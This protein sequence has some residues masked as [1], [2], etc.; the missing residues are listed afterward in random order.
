VGPALENANPGIVSWAQMFLTYGR[1]VAPGRSGIVEDLPGHNSS[2]KR[3][4]LLEYG[5]RLEA[6][7]EVEPYMHADLRARGHV[8]Y[9]ETAA[10]TAHLNINRPRSFLV[11]HMMLGQKYAATR[12]AQWSWF[13]R[14]A[15][16]VATP[17]VGPLQHTRAALVNILRSGVDRR[18][19]LSTLPALLT[20]GLAR[21]IGEMRGLAFGV[22]RSATDAIKFE[23]HRYSHL[24]AADR[25]KY[26]L[27]EAD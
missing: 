11:E 14:A 6:M 9:F 20:G 13:R 25:R 2:Y 19:L 15:Y 24:T 3:V 8:L 16:I 21:S 23:V 1:W 27:R 17:L 10:R 26:E 22:G 12:G 18:L 4:A 7:M 5:S